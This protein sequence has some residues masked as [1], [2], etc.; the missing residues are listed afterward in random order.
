MNGRDANGGGV[1]REMHGKGGPG[2]TIIGD[3]RACYGLYSPQLG[4]CRDIFVYLPPGYAGGGGPY[5]VI[6]MQDGQNLFDQAI[7]YAGEWR[8]DETLES[9]AADGVEAIVVGVANG[10]ARRLEEYNA[11]AGQGGAYLDFLVD[12]VKPLIDQ[13][14]HTRPERGATG[15]LGSSMGGLIALHA[16]FS[17]PLVF[18][19]AG[20]L[21]HWMWIAGRIDPGQ[22]CGFVAGSEYAP[23]RLYL[24]IGDRECVDASLTGQALAPERLVADTRRLRDALLAKGYAEG[25]D[26]KYLE[27]AGGGHGEGDWAARLAAVFR[28]LLDAG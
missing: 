7:A 19:R 6:Y 26:F 20:A 27:I 5:P 25:R 22:V 17:R 4:D 24:D 9:L 3:V 1:W 16:F 18:G 28:F 14:F 12:T 15:I 2:H 13:R 23:G 10:G 21:S 8:V 11:Y